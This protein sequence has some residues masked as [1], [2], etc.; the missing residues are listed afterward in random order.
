VSVAETTAKGVQAARDRAAYL[1]EVRAH[2]IEA[3]SNIVGA[4][5]LTAT[6][7]VGAAN[8]GVRR[9][10]GARLGRLT[11]ALAVLDELAEGAVIHTGPRMRTS[12]TR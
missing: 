3:R 7:L 8:D 9:V 12:G 4:I 1:K 5:E 10:E 11:E 6:E 2:L